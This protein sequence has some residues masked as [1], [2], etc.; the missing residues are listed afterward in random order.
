MPMPMPM[1]MSKPPTH[2]TGGVSGSSKPD[3]I[4]RLKG[5][6]GWPA[7]C[8]ISMLAWLVEGTSTCN[9]MSGQLGVAPLPSFLYV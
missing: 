2:W 3:E 9:C 8:T 4:G 1:P 5:G 7:G 6:G